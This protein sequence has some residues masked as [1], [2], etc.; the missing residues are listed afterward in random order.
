MLLTHACNLLCLQLHPVVSQ[1]LISLVR[2][3]LACSHIL[4]IMHTDSCQLSCYK[5]TFK[6]CVF[7][8]EHHQNVFLKWKPH[9]NR[10]TPFLQLEWQ[11]PSDPFQSE[12]A[13]DVMSLLDIQLIVLWQYLYLCRTPQT[14]NM[15]G[16][17][18][19]LH[20]NGIL[21]YDSIVKV[22]K[23]RTSL[24]LPACLS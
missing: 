6:F 16:H 17:T 23:D 21:R 24:K 14:L 9:S 19:C 5:S 13:S 4:N 1:F 20:H 8:H 22:M 15:W 7:I 18:V 3:H 12:L 2:F 11:R 10:E